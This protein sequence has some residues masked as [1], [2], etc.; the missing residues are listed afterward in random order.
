M[1]AIKAAITISIAKGIIKPAISILY[2]KIIIS[3]IQSK[4]FNPK[5]AVDISHICRK[6][7]TNRNL[8]L[9]EISMLCMKTW[10][11]NRV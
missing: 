10:R 4:S 11:F 2:L 5:N 7:F 9:N 8:V 1:I 6:T 3:Q